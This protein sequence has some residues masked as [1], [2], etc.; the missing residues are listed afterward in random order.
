LL[1]VLETL[2]RRIVDAACNARGPA[3][4]AKV[5]S[6]NAICA[7]DHVSMGISSLRRLTSAAVVVTEGCLEARSPVS[8]AS[9]GREGWIAERV[10][11]THQRRSN[12]VIRYCS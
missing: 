12:G 6:I 4:L 5:A 9:V 10:G 3:P 11:V 8:W 1:L 2:D 7:I